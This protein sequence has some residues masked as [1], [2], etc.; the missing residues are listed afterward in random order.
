VGPNGL[1]KAV[2]LDGEPN[3]G[4]RRVHARST[5]GTPTCGNAPNAIVPENRKVGGSTPP[6]A[7]RDHG[8]TCTFVDLIKGAGMRSSVR[9]QSVSHSR[10]GH[11]PPDTTRVLT[12]DDVHAATH[13]DL[14][15]AVDART[16]PSYPLP[17]YP[18]SAAHAMAW[19][20]C[21]PRTGPVQGLTADPGPQTR[22]SACAR[23]PHER[24]G[25]VRLLARA[26][27]RLDHASRAAAAARARSRRGRPAGSSAPGLP[28]RRRRR[29]PGGTCL[30]LR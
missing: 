2:T 29:V 21:R 20:H 24:P 22:S 8:L 12:C 17:V 27:R 19:R 1:H 18:R 7:T 28:R 5:L 13:T 11:G 6:L 14:D 23:R 10:D 16:H 15:T 3:Q 25:P 30:S 9:P 4:A 26:E